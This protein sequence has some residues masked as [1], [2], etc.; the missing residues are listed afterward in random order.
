MRLKYLRVH[1]FY[2]VMRPF[3][4]RARQRRMQLFARLMRAAAG[5]SILDLGGEPEFWNSFGARLEIIVLNLPGI[6][7]TEVSSHHAMRCIVGDACNVVGFAD[8]QFDIAFS[9]SVIEH[10]GPA[11]KQEAFAHE[12]RRLG[13]S[14]WV[15]TPS[16]WFPIEA[17]CGMPFWWFYPAVVR[18]FFLERWRRKLPS[19]TEMV[20]GTTVLAR[21]DLKRL[22]PEATIVIERFCGI[23]KSYIA[24]FH[25]GAQAGHSASA[26]SLQKIVSPSVTEVSRFDS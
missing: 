15:Q 7:K 24:Y 1:T 17:H 21:R 13:K 14:Y 18:K 22:F 25:G 6:A 4:A 19:W 26:R 8:R 11:A 16:R 12:V 23:P 10:V 9:N 3:S 20:E 5:T 2:A